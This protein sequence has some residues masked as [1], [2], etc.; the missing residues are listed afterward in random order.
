VV[1]SRDFTS[2]VILTGDRYLYNDATYLSE[3]LA[4]FAAEWKHRDDISTRAQNMLRLENDIKSL[5]TFANRTYTNELAIQKT[6]LRD[7]LGGK[8]N[9]W[10]PPLSDT[11]P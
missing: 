4:E 11:L 7:L 3:R 9:A 2:A 1:N 10:P 5:Q 6:V 8:S